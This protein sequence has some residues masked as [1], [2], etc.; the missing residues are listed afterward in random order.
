[1]ALEIVRPLILLSV[2]LVSAFIAHPDFTRVSQ[3][4]PGVFEVGLWP[5]EGRPKFRAVAKEL[6]IRH[7]PSV[8]SPI[9]RRLRVSAGQPVTFDQTWYRTDEAGTLQVLARASI[10]GRLFGSVR[11][12]SRDAYYSR[13]VSEQPIVFDKDEVV[14]YLQNRAEGTCFLRTAGQVFEADPC[15]ARKNPAFRLIT[16]PKTEWWIRVV[17]ARVPIGWVMIGNETVEESGRSY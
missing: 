15:P 12:I 4:S 5:G 10:S 17:V 13:A 3:R 9:V 7:V 14:E 1:M 11:K 16:E 2:C 8:S 6:P